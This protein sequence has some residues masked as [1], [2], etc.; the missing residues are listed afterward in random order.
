MGRGERTRA[1]GREERGWRREQTGEG[2]SGRSEKAGDER[3]HGLKTKVELGKGGMGRSKEIGVER[4]EDKGRM[5]DGRCS[6]W[7]PLS[8]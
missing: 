5:R 8:L 1:E 7:V 4:E 3:R 2:G 6:V